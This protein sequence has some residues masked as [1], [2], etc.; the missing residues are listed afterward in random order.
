MTC[1]TFNRLAL[2]GID[3]LGHFAVV[4][5]GR[6]PGQGQDD[7]EDARYPQVHLVKLNRRG[8]MF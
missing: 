3:A 1:L 6:G 8:F 7:Q 2:D 5:V 4:P